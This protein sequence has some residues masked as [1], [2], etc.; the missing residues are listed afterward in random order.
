MSSVNDERVQGITVDCLL[1]HREPHI[2][3]EP[4]SRLYME[5]QR[6]IPWPERAVHCQM[7]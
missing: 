1:M 4:T 3:V 7:T 2:Q 6:I 5:G